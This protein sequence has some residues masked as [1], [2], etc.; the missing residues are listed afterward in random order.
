MQA[1]PP[2]SLETA[3]ARRAD[4]LRGAG[5]VLMRTGWPIGSD[6]KSPALDLNLVPLTKPIGDCRTCQTPQTQMQPVKHSNCHRGLAR[7]LH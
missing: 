2:A 5:I 1:D 7:Q 6:E 4:G 3:R